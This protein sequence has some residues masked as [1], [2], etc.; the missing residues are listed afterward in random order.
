[1]TSLIA[2]SIFFFGI[3]LFVAGT[4]LRDRLVAR[5]GE[6]PFRGVFSLASVAGLIWMGWTYVAVKN[7]NFLW[8]PP[9]WLPQAGGAIILIAFLFAVIGIST[10]NPTVVQSQDLLKKGDAAATGMV[11]VT[12]HPFLWG[13]I[14]WASFHLAVNADQASLVFFGTLLALA[15][16]GMFSIDAKRK[17]AFG[18]AWD[19]FAAKTSVVPFLAILSGQNHFSLKEIGVLRP[20]AAVVL[21]GA[22]LFGHGWLFGIVPFDLPG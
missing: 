13:V 7:T 12:R 14:I 1:M 8:T 19:A 4:P 21:Y 2:A 17:R 22:I 9:D 18:E 3:H 16:F 20:V 5:M 6:G 10:P 15:F 11:R